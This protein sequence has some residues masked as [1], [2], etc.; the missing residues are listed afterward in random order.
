MRGLYSLHNSNT[1]YDCLC[2]FHVFFVNVFYTF[3][4]ASPDVYAFYFPTLT[5]SCA[6]APYGWRWISAW[7]ADQFWGPPSLL[8]NGYWSSLPVV[9]RSGRDVNH[10]PPSSADV[11]NE[12]GCTCSPCIQRRGVKRNECT[13]YQYCHCRLCNGLHLNKSPPWLYAVCSSELN[14]TS[15]RCIMPLFLY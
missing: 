15:R 7:H 9:K 14:P 10:R 12:W 6:R 11:K 2:S 1:I 13:L 8:F 4:V 3:L 5:L